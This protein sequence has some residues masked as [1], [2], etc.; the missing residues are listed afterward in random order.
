M[1]CETHTISLKPADFFTRSP[2]IDVPASTQKE[3]KS[4]LF[5]NGQ[6]VKGECCKV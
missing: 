3:N 5:T 1:P 2:A 6:D 4:V